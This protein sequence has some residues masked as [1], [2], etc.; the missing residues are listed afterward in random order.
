MIR[1]NL[2]GACL[3]G[4]SYRVS[5]YTNGDSCI[6]G[7]SISNQGQVF[8]SDSVFRKFHRERFENRDEFVTVILES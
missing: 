7:D 4:T 3:V 2:G 5:E 6:S 8:V 1:R